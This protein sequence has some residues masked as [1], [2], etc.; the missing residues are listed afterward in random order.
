MSSHFIM[1]SSC[2]YDDSLMWLYTFNYIEYISWCKHFL[3][4][5]PIY[6]YSWSGSFLFICFKK[7]KRFLTTP[8]IINKHY[9]IAKDV[10]SFFLYID[11]KRLI[12]IKSDPSVPRSS[13]NVLK[14]DWMTKSSRDTFLYPLSTSMGIICILIPNFLK[15]HSH[16]IWCFKCISRCLDW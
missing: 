7:N 9:C 1:I 4:I 5:F 11:Y 14:S 16:Y 13:A 15:C 6:F 3:N 12:L 10:R 8:F 2:I